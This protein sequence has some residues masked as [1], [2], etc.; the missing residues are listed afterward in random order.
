MAHQP[1]DFPGLAAAL[2]DRVS[3]LLLQWLPAGIERAGRWYV[4]D[5]DGAAGE[6]ANVNMHTGQWIDN[7]APDEDCGGDLI[8][9]YARIH[10]LNNGQAA[11]QLM[12][13]L[14]WERPQASAHA[15]TPRAVASAPGAAP[16]DEQPEPPLADDG[17][18]TPGHP[19]RKSDRWQPVVPVPKHAPRPTTFK[20]GFKNKKSDVW[21]DMESVRHWAYEFEGELYGYV[22]RFE[23]VSSEGELVKDTLPFT[24]C[25]DTSDPRGHQR[26]H[27]KQWPAPRPLFVPATLLSGDPSNVPVVIV[28]GE[29]CA[30][31]GH[32]L[33]GHEFDFVSW[34]GGCKT[35][36]FARWG[37]LMGRT[38]Y[39]WPDCD[40]QRERPTK[41]ER[42]NPDFNP[43]SKPIRPAHKQPGMQAMVNIGTLLLADQGCTVNMCAIPDPGAVSDGWD[44][45][46]AI[47]Q[48]WDAAMVRA[49]IRGAR[50]FVPPADE[51]R[52][53]AGGSI[54]TPSFAGAGSGGSGG[55]G[56]G[57]ADDGEDPS[58]AWRRHLLSSE[59]GA[60]KAVRENAVLALDGLPDRNMPGAPEAMG[61][62][63]FN[64]FTNDVVK[65][66]PTPWGT[67]AGVWDEV[68]ELEM[69]NWLA[70]ELWLP[71]M[72]RGTLEEAVSMVAKRHRFHPVRDEFNAL[73]GTWDGT[74]RLGTWVR[75][76]CL[77]EDEFDDKDPLQQY[78]ARVGTWLVMAICARVLDPGCKYDYM[79]IFE[80]P[81]G[82][83]KSTLS[84]LLGGEY[85]ADTGLVLGDK[86]SYQNLQGVLVYEWG[87]LD[88]LTKT[89]VTKVKQFISSQK[90][91]FRASFDRRAKD[92]PR[93]VVFI[94]TTNE[95]HY[96]VDQTGNRRMWPVRITRQ[97]D[98]PWFR[99]NRSQLF[100]EALH[101]L[102]AG[103]RFHPTTKEQRE[104]FEPQQQRRQIESAIQAA[105]L[106]YLYDDDQKVGISGENGTLVNNIAAPELLSRLGISVDKQSH[107]LLR[108]VT[109]A[110]RQ[111]GWER[112]RSTR[113]DR[114]WMFRR[115]G[116]QS[117]ASDSS[118][119]APTQGESPAGAND[120]YP[121]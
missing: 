101:Y 68:D 55:G 69:G 103:D 20:W 52:A 81:Q 64:D 97:I 41:A 82:W 99:E 94:G 71:S 59:K 78:L 26:W 70:R 9:L 116:T 61:V 49:F 34:P 92:Y 93:Q 33:L 85:F 72:P 84:R 16:A 23:R 42:D 75:R 24:W 109:A 87:E 60:I 117:R 3:S 32:E 102:A 57:A 35:W 2:L 18:T 6:S 25:T 38:V 51:A 90:D 83:G 14:G 21:I 15:A 50:T 39:L 19:T 27:A 65:L 8:S 73:Q 12:R 108:Q 95:D 110:L 79:V 1:I 104:L 4:G 86:D 13:D 58:T 17:P 106:R 100:A 62:I 118:S 76:C 37:T 74:K 7:A 36:S 98:L 40:A 53:K 96:L 89:E 29:K 115:P 67:A 43:Q 22:A 46:D 80:G 56:S 28:E 48:G 45:A 105:V 107:V 10:G 112:Y 30:Q 31:A 88:S 121:F 91:R 66:K 120:D 11:R 111:A 114:P 47:E 5:F 63:A 119:S 44:I 54:S 113:G 77:E